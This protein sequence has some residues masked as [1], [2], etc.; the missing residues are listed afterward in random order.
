M[1][2]ASFSK[3]RC[4]EM[5]SKQSLC[6]NRELLNHDEVHDDDVCCLGKDWNENVS[7]VGKKET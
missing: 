2:V 5:K 4:T 1:S 3:I 7:F 6:N